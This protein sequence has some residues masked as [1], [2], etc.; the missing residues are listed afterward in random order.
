[1]NGF[2]HPGDDESL[3]LVFFKKAMD[4]I[5]NTRPKKSEWIIVT[6][7]AKTILEVTLIIKFSF[8]YSTVLYN[9][10]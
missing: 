6:D 2:L 8:L 3:P 5:D 4:T 10:H 9:I 7:I 1:M